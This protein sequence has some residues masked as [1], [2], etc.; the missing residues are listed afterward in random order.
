MSL[1]HSQSDF[2]YEQNTDHVNDENYNPYDSSYK[3]EDQRRPSE[4]YIYWQQYQNQESMH[5]IDN[6]RIE[7]DSGPLTEYVD[8]Q[9]ESAPV[10]DYL[11]L[12]E[13][14]VVFPRLKESKIK[15]YMLY[16]VKFLWNDKEFEISRRFSDFI[17]LRKAIKRF[18]PFTFV[19]PM[20][21]K[22]II[23]E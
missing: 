19:F 1:N 4:E 18:L 16:K 23:V 12:K 14:Q 20:H 2:H 15:N 21:R 10:L 5:R 22:K 8:L 11:P 13:V 17:N 6:N 3:Y 7:N 9:P